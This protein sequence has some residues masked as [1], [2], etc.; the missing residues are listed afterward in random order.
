MPLFAYLGKG[1]L[2]GLGL[3]SVLP[4]P[5]RVLEMQNIVAVAGRGW[6]LTECRD[7]E[8]L[9]IGDGTDGSMISYCTSGECRIQSIIGPC[10]CSLRADRL[11]ATKQSV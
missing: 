6:T 10:G 8:H 11:Q 3:V 2:T 4:H 7:L 9:V 1:N 5:H